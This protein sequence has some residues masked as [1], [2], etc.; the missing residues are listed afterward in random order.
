MLDLM[1]FDEAQAI[2]WLKHRRVLI[3]LFLDKVPALQLVE[4][5]FSNL[6]DFPY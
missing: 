1:Y 3:L 2:E 5:A 6:K 4:D